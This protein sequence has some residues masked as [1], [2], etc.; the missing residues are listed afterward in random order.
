[1]GNYTE[2]W[3]LEEQRQRQADR[4]ATRCDCCGGIIRRGELKYTLGVGRTDLTV[5][6]DCK[7]ELVASC[8]EHGYE[9][10]T[11]C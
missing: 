6:E 5:C 8:E 2:P 1:M 11:L 4:G 7:G 3:E 9:E 10:G